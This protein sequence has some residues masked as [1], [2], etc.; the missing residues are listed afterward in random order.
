MKKVKDCKRGAKIDAKV[1]KIHLGIKCRL[2]GK[3]VQKSQKRSSVRIP[4]WS[5]TV[6]LTDP[7]D[8]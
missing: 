7:E 1:D 4:T 6:V 2:V 8:A 5:P 3:V